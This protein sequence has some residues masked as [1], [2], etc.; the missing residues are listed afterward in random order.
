M[1]V[2][3]ESGK[4][5]LSFGPFDLQVS[6]R[7]LTKEGSP[8]ELSSR[9]LDLLIALT[10]SPNEV[11]SKKQLLAQVW[12]D[13]F[14]EEANLR[15]H[16]MNLRK[17]LGD[18]E[19]GARYITT[20]PGRGYCFVASV[21]RAKSLDVAPTTKF[22]R[23][24]LPSRPSRM[25]GREIDVEKI[26]TQLAR[27]QLVTISGSGGIGKTT[28]ALA[29]AHRL[30]EAFQGA[31][32]FVDLGMMHDPDVV[33]TGLAS[34]LGLPAAAEIAR[35][36]LLAYLCDK[37]V[38]LILD[39]CEHLIDT[40]ASLAEDIIA[41]APNVR[42]LATSRE[43]LRV[44][45]EYIHRLEGLPFPSDGVGITA[46]SLE[47]FPA[48]RLF[49]DRAM[50]SGA[51]LEVSDADAPIVA[52]ICR[53][54]D[55]VALAIEL[56][57]R[58]VDSCGLSQT[59]QLLDHHLSLEW[60]G[61]RTA[62]PRQ[63]TLHATLEWSH[64]L[65]TKQERLVLRRLAVFVGHFTLDAALEVVSDASLGRAAVFNAIDSLVSKSILAVQSV[66]GMV[67]YRLLDTT[68]A[69]ALK[70]LLEPDEHE[71]L[72]IRHA[73]C[74][75]RLI[76]QADAE[77]NHVLAN[78]ERGP[79]FAIINN[80][81]SALDWCFGERGDVG[82]GVELAAAA[83]AA[84]LAMSLTSEACFWSERALSALG[85]QQR[86]SREEMLLRVGYGIGAVD[87][88][89]EVEA[90][91]TALRRGVGIADAS[92]DPADLIACLGLLNFFYFRRADF[93]SML[94]I[95]RRA[96]LAAATVDNPAAVGLAHSMMG[97]ALHLAGDQNRARVELEAGVEHWSRAGNVPLYLCR[98]YQSVSESSIGRAIWLQGHPE[99]ALARTH[100]TIARAFKID[101]PTVIAVTLTFAVSVFLWTG[102][103]ESAAKYIDAGIYTAKS[104]ALISLITIG[105]ARQAE[106]AIQ[107][108]DYKSGV[109][110]LRSCLEK[111]QSIRS[112]ALVTEFNISLVQGLLA[113]G[114][115]SEAEKELDQAI[116]LVEEK[117]HHLYTPELLRLKGK[118][119]LAKD[120]PDEA[121]S[122]FLQAITLSR[123]QGARAWELRIATDI[124]AL[125][126]GTNRRSEAR[127]SLRPVLAEFSQGWHTADLRAATSVLAAVASDH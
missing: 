111:V 44:A 108:G 79:L 2:E 120:R 56:A 50:A 75:R 51:R 121:E 118:L 66:G 127:S 17:A 25:V 81:R 72:S 6:E 28:V 32:L 91:E 43:P 57:A 10:S 48:T 59:A 117:G 36:S 123:H 109:E 68:R 12:P 67:Q 90:V 58:R 70:T 62:P 30:S 22:R 126:A 69:Y 88:L 110:R 96:R 114:R 49:L 71:Q 11:V 122:H 38:M 13:V 23:S 37:R 84:F 124:A 77:W 63:R 73:N 105:Q 97:T 27:S 65:L 95:A 76:A 41:A 34:M 116:I 100:E 35:P 9:S 87:L 15:V 98:E 16:M 107:R 8:V 112:M 46:A 14:V 7:L 33:T 1:V 54:L 29:T 26:L 40:A 119:L 42:I 3:I 85:D 102:D 31:V 52:G 64:A 83:S 47:N 4:D 94:E 104:H 86:G 92:G 78:P 115:Y 61:S 93:K 82:T 106:L 89:G 55:G 19:Q 53:R 125:Q 21:S 80:V 60:T 20:L 45:G 99:A 24:N 18:G 39:T 5:W 74:Y 103:Q 101:Q 113:L